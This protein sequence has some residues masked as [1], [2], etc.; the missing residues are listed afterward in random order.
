MYLYIHIYHDFLA[1]EKTCFHHQSA[2]LLQQRNTFHSVKRKE[3]TGQVTMQLSKSTVNQE[4]L[5]MYLKPLPPP[6]PCYLQLVKDIK[7]QLRSRRRIQ[8]MKREAHALALPAK[9]PECCISLLS[10][11]LQ[12]HMSLSKPHRDSFFP[13]LEL[14]ELSSLG[15]RW[16]H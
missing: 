8:Q 7:D 5:I 4:L 2:L 1:T 12:S 6:D 14:G 3:K 10:R 11:R 16:I 9:T 13:L 15:A